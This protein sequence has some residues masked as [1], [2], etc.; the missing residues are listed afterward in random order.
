MGKALILAQ[1]GYKYRFYDDDA[2]A[3]R[4]TSFSGRDALTR[5]QIAAK[6]L[7]IVC[8]PY[9]NFLSASIP[10]QRRDIHLKK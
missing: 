3:R 2:K 10:V 5:A 1:V 6:E 8:Y 7:G 4:D 9:R